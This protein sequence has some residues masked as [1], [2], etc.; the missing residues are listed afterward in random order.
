MHQRLTNSVAKPA[1][2]PDCSVPATGCAGTMATVFGRCF[3]SAA[4]TAPLTEPTSETMAPGAR[5]GA[6]SCATASIAPTGTQRMTRSAPSTASAAL[7]G[8]F[9]GKAEFGDLGAHV[10]RCVTGDDRARQILALGDAG[11]RRADQADADQRQR[12]RRAAPRA[13]RPVRQPRAGPCIPFRKS[14]SAATTR[15]LA[16]SVPTVSRRHCG[17]T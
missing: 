12:G 3:V 7:L 10:G 2:G 11:E 17:R 1:S 8:D 16:S 9:V 5:C 6:I 14:R 13:G 4:S 15:R